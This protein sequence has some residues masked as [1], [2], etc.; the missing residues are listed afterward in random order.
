MPPSPFVIQWAP[1]VAKAAP[2][3][4]T[5]LDVAMGRGRHHETLARA[6]FRV[7]GVDISFE[8]M[9]E[10]MGSVDPEAGRLRGWCADLTMYPLP[11]KR[12]DLVLVTKYLQRDL[13][14]ALKDA[15]V[16]GGVVMYETFT[17]HQLR[18]GRGPVS[19]KHLLEPGEL[20]SCFS[21]YEVL[22]YEE[23]AEPDALASIVA[24]R[25]F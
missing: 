10:A 16:P 5:A 24:R 17:L 21:D 13:V 18:H 20:L 11:S 2:A 14:P 12:F 9:R 8:A 22:F 1:R 7:F 4:P 15:V 3:R 23:S 25:R 6:G 19:S